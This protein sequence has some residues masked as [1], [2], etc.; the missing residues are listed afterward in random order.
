[1][2]ASTAS[3]YSRVECKFELSQRQ[4]DHKDRSNLY[5]L[6]ILANFLLTSVKVTKINLTKPEYRVRTTS[7]NGNLNLERY[8]NLFPLF[9]TKYLDYKD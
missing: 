3:K 7:L 4:K 8:L 2:R 1:V 6:E 5:F 9:G